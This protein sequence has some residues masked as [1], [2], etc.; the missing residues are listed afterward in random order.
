MD[1]PWSEMEKTISWTSKNHHIMDEDVRELTDD[2]FEE[3]LRST[4]DLVIVEFYSTT[5]PN[6]RSMEP[7]YVGLAREMG[8]NALF[9]RMNVQRERINAMRHGVLGV[10]TFIFFCKGK[11][12][13]ELVG[14]INAT[15]LRNT[16]MDHIKHRMECAARITPVSYEMDGYG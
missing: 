13:G 3:V 8:R 15:L 9:T 12:I 16:I 4:G 14:A 2:D 1:A 5:C 7:V 11:P 10:P 6:C